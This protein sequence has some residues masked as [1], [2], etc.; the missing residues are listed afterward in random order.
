MND[1][2]YE[3][4]RVRVHV[5]CTIIHIREYFMITVLC[6]VTLHYNIMYIMYIRVL[7][8]AIKHPQL[9]VMS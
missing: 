5:L 9:E 8:I 7:K 4:I 3:Y 6:T 2:E 1:H